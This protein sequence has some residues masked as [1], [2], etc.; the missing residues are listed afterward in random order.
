M[1]VAVIVQAGGDAAHACEKA[2]APLGRG[3]VLKRVLE[4][5]ARIDGVDLVACVTPDSPACDPVAAEAKRCGV[6]VVR[7]PEADP[8]AAC[9]QAATAIGAETIIL[10]TADRPFLDPALC[11]RVLALLGESDADYACNDL[12]ATWPHGLDCE[13]FPARLLHWADALARDCGERAR[14]TSWIRTN[15]DLKKA[16]LTG[17]GGDFAHMRWTLDWPEDLAFAQAVFSHMGERA[18]TASAAEL[19]AFCLRRPD[20]SALN[21]MRSDTLRLTAYARA[22][23]ETPPMSLAQPA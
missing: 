15:P 3:S 18:A 13:I 7:G 1:T 8:L 19:A 11:A 5:C 2:L 9:A 14:I 4:R 23:F 17:P 6:T 20:V 21:A 12:P 16:S 22:D 10:A